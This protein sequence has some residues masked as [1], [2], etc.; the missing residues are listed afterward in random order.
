MIPHY[1]WL[2]TLSDVH[3]IIKT[4]YLMIPNETLRYLMIPYLT[5]QILATISQ[6][7]PDWTRIPDRQFWIGSGLSS[8]VWVGSRR[9]WIGS[10]WSRRVWIGSEWSRWVWIGSERSRSVWNGSGWSRWF[11]IGSGWSRWVWNGSGEFGSFWL[12]T[13]W[14]CWLRIRPRNVLARNRLQKFI[15]EGNLW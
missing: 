3:C 15:F 14:T 5:P 9:V 6:V 2:I 11:W 1:K 12:L 7:I 8:W 13:G 10:G 4:S